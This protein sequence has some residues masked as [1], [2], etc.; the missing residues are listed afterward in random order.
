MGNTYFFVAFHKL[1][2]FIEHFTPKDFFS[3]STIITRTRKHQLFTVF[4]KSTKTSFFL[5]SI[6]PELHITAK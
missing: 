6:F 2:N 4:L 5:V 1:N 3:F